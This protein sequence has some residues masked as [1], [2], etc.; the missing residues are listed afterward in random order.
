M[1]PGALATLVELIP[2]QRSECRDAVLC[3]TYYVLC[4]MCYVL[5]AMCEV[6]SIM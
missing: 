6:S 4:A 1:R 3:T 5:C 2:A